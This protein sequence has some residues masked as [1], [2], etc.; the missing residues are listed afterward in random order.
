MTIDDLFKRIVRARLP[1]LAC[2]VL[3]PLLGVLLLGSRQHPG[4][5]GQRTGTGVRRRALLHDRGGREQLP[6][7]GAGDDTRPGPG[8]LADAHV[9]ARRDRSGRARHLGPAP[10]RVH[11]RGDRACK[12]TDPA[13]AAAIVKA[14]ANRVATFMNEG[15]RSHFRSTLADVDAQIATT[16][17][18]RDGVT[19][20]LAAA[21]DPRVRDTLRARLASLASTSSELAQ[22]RTSLV[23]HSDEVEAREASRALR[24][25][26]IAQGPSAAASDVAGSGSCDLRVHRGKTGSGSGCPR[27]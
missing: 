14:L 16:N 26:R 8:A 18:T 1:L 12:D 15:S 6:R 22:Q 20:S 25:S 11:G 9:T 2:F 4:L 21:I 7:T 19:T 5:G 13:A 10:R 27:S 24:V 23:G 3:V 17:R